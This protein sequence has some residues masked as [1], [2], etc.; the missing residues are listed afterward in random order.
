LIITLAVASFA[1]FTGLRAQADTSYLLIQGPFGAGNSEQTFEWQVN[2][3][4]GVLLNG[5]DLLTAVFG[6]P[7]L[8]GSF[9]GYNYYTSG[10]ATQGAGYIDYGSDP[11][12]LTDPF[13]GSITVGSST[14]NTPSDFSSYWNA[15][16]AGGGGTFGSDDSGAPYP[17][18]SWTYSNDGSLGRTLSNDS[19][20]AWVFGGNVSTV[21][22]A[23]NA[24]TVQ[25]F[26]DATVINVVPEPGSVALLSISACG[27]LVLWKRRRA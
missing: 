14:V 2:Y 12:Q 11:T 6:S 25:D 21:D 9:D 8:N 20:D 22:G 1:A 26:S 4:A 17:D 19:F 15:F 7:S 16:V 10:D 24:P 23:S 5:Q 3:Q 18:G 27:M 13:L